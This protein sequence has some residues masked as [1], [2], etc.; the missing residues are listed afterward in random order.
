MRAVLSSITLMA[1]LIS[2]ANTH[3]I[4]TC[5]GKFINPLTDICWSCLFP[6]TIGSTKV[7]SG[8]H[9]DTKNPNS[10]VCSCKMGHSTRYGLSM[11]FWE[12]ISLV[13]VTRTPFCFVNMAG[14]KLPAGHFYPK[15]N[16]RTQ[17][18]KKEVFYHVHWYHYPLL[19][20]LKLLT[21]FTCM[22]MG[23]W[24]LLYLTELDPLWN[25]DL[26]SFII[27]PESML[28]ANPVAQAACAVDAVAAST[29]HPI[30][31]LFW[32]M[33]AQGSSYPLTG[34]VLGQSGGVQASTLLAERM[35]FKLHRFRILPDSDSK[36]LCRMRHKLIIPKSR[37]R[38]QMTYPI[39]SSNE[40][41][42][43]KP[44][45]HST[46]IWGSG[47]EF[48]YKGEDFGYLIFRKRN[49]CAL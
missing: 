1:L 28:F 39:A 19:S 23:D 35:A 40:P 24:D 2:A 13:D 33:G 4:S 14:L 43:C 9:A 36:K 27:S 42:G 12:P 8:N 32:C 18:E 10:M 3:A 45:G 21:E 7:V 6:I 17:V 47:R 26:L 46:A 38:Y 25:D 20:L 29:K 49:C 22:E 5:Q 15:G 41:N 30:D 44:F 11:G 31:S 16:A 37:Y 34:T 48:P